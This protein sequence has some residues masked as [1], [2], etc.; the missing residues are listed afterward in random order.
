MAKE[1]QAIR[2]LGAWVGNRVNELDIWTPTLEVLENKVNFWLKS[3]PSL[4][5]RSYISKMEPGGRTQYKTMV[6]G[7]SQKTE[8]DIQ[9]IIKRI[10]WD[11]QTPKVNHETTILPYELGGKKTLDLPTRNKSIY[12][13][14]LQKYIRTGPNRPLWAYPADKLIANDIP[15]SYNVTDL[16]TAT[17]TLLQTWSTRKLGSAST[18]PLSLFKML[19]VGRVFNVTFAP[20]IVPNKIK[21]TLPLWF[22]PG[23]KPGAYAMNNGDLAEC[24]R[25]VHRVLTVGD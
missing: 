2:V 20:P 7:M 6:Q 19:E 13:K 12:M 21:D 23:R 24:L 25:D 17:N 15:K 10:M 18:L 22:H 16:D 9:K 8:K 1:G 5:G 4:E 14:R 3:N 11:D